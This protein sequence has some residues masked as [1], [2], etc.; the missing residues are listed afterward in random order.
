MIKSVYIAAPWAKKEYAGE[1]RKQCQDAGIDVT[2]GW[3]DFPGDSHD[4][5][6]LK[7]EAKNDWNDVVRAEGFFLLNLQ[8]RG[9][10]TS[11]KAVETGLALAYGKPIFMVGERS[12][13]FQ[14]LSQVRC[15]ESVGAAIEGIK[16]YGNGLS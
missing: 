10:E 9:E 11:G 5:E 13:V 4:V 16:D 15:Y 7:T 6:V 2:S 14:Y 8:K 12:N 3:I 1:I